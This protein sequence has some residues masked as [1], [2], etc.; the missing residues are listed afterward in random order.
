[1][2]SAGIAVSTLKVKGEVW[3]VGKGF[4]KTGGSWVGGGRGGEREDLRS[5]KGW[6]SSRWTSHVEEKVETRRKKEGRGC[7]QNEGGCFC[8]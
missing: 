5:Q 3:G 2:N 7:G 6:W 8:Y 4:I 1:L